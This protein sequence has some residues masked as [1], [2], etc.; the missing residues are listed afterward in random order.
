MRQQLCHMPEIKGFVLHEG[1]LAFTVRKAAQDAIAIPPRDYRKRRSE[2]P[3]FHHIPS[4]PETD[5]PVPIAL[6]FDQIVEAGRAASPPW[7]WIN[8]A[9]IAC[10]RNKC[11]G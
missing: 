4:R 3:L 7:V 11:Y 2:I 5:A 8:L 10:I 9:S 1:D 6:S